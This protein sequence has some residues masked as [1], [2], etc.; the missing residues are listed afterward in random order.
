[1]HPFTMIKKK[2]LAPAGL[3]IVAIASLVASALRA[4]PFSKAAAVDF[5]REIPSRSLRGLAV[6][7]DGRLTAGPQLR[8]LSGTTPAD[9]L[10]SLA[11]GGEGGDWH[12]GTGPLGRILKVTLNEAAGSYTATTLCSLDD[13]HVF[14][15]ARLADGS[16]LAGTSPQG[17]LVLVREGKVTA[18]VD[19]PVDSVFDLLVEPSTIAAASPQPQ[20]STSKG[21]GSKAGATRGAKLG[22][23]LVATG[24]PGRIY[25]VDLDR[26]AESGKYSGLNAEAGPLAERGITLFGEIRDRNVRRL[27]RL[28]DGRIVA[29]SAPRGSVYAFSASGG[30][31]V[32]LQ[33]NRD[34]EVTDLLARPDGGLYALVVSAGTQAESRINRP[35]PADA[36]SRESGS[37]TAG[38]PSPEQPP[39]NP[40]GPQNPSAAE[41][42][43]TQ[44][45]A[46]QASPTVAPAEK[47]T[48]RTQLLSLSAQGQV[49]TLMSRS[50]L[51]FYR[52]TLHDGR[53]LLA[54][55]DQGD[56]AGYD[57]QLRVAYTYAGSAS[58]QVNEIR[59][60]PGRDGLFLA[61]RNNAAGLAL[62]D[63]AARGPREAETKRIDL[64]M[65]GT[66]GML[67][68]N[69]LR[70]VLPGAVALDVRANSG[71]D[72]VEGWTDWLSFPAE[73]AASASAPAWRPPVPTVR[74]RYVKLRVKLPESIPADFALDRLAW[75]YLPQNR[76]PQLTEFRVLPPNFG[77]I[78]ASES[79]PPASASLSQVVSA[80]ASGGGEGGAPGKRRSNFM[81]SQVVP[82][83]GTQVF[84]WTVQD[85]DGDNVACTLSIRRDGDDKWI[86]VVVNTQEP[87]AQIELPTLEEGVYFTKLC[88]T[89]LAPRP[90]AERLSI[91]YEGD[92]MIVDRTPPEILSASARIEGERLLIEVRGRDARSLLTTLEVLCNNGVRETVEQPQDGIRDGREETFVV[93]LPLARASGANA[94][95]VTLYDASGNAATRRVRW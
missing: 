15:L 49:E 56:L 20:A 90:V 40:P 37:S 92:D 85:A 17:L 53:L 59:P 68:S 86:D 39:R 89:E 46:A 87:Y 81:S 27:A 84:L 26:F 61:L 91:T 10:W 48:G 32:F 94:A 34:A 67:R 69:R 30:T 71:A 22:Q 44:Q 73:D 36:A 57:P 83:P 5:F 25:R 33:E 23:A 70:G 62:L 74:G 60:V 51:S 21:R 65:T 38:G 2:H 1:M 93:E 66:L 77:L 82:A 24:N 88:F 28:T 95:E 11:P 64:G 8:E 9:L 19:L 78:P 41:R 7:S 76:R 31:P 80:A 12:I 58:S 55:G 29:G 63:F 50:N 14:A 16:L 13:A 52:M 3:A 75:H 45:Q 4:E 6:R 42:G 54:G 43:P 35:R 18:Q 47:F 79:S 72:E